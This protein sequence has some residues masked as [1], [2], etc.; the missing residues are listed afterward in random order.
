MEKKTGS[1]QNFSMQDAMRLAKSDSA[2]QLLALLQQQNG[3]ALQQAMAQ[4][5]SGNY[6]QAK[7]IM[8]QMLSNPEA[9]AL[10]EKMKG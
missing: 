4:A 9:A 8:S 7:Q 5:S 3:D 6:D 10:F 1:F 2:Q